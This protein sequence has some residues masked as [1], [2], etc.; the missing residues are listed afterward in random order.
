MSAT[1]HAAEAMSGLALRGASN[2]GSAFARD[3]GV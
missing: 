1:K 3:D 2:K